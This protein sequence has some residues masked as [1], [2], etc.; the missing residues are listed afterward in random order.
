[1][2]HTLLSLINLNMDLKHFIIVQLIP[3]ILNN[4][5]INLKLQYFK[6]FFLNILHMLILLNQDEQLHKDHLQNL[7]KFY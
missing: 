1:M 7:I 3:F 4:Q 2:V 5:Y 6:D